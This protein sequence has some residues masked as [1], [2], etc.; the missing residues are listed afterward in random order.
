MLE[1][2]LLSLIV[3]L[4]LE[5]G[6]HSHFK[7]PLAA[8]WQGVETKTWSCTLCYTCINCRV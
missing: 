6:L 2:N 1:L 4:K 8:A 7:F 5:A 3:G